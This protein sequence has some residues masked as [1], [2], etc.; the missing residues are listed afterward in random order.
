MRHHPSKSNIVWTV[1]FSLLTTLVLNACGDSNNV[2]APAPPAEPGALAIATSSLPSGNVGIFYDIT[3]APAGGNAPYTWSLSSGSL[4]N[5]LTLAS[6]GRISGTPA[7]VQT[8]SPT[9]RLQDSSVPTGEIVTKQLPMSI[10]A[11]PQPTITTPSPL[12][13]GIVNQVYS[14]T[15]LTV[16][17][18]TPP[19]TWSTVVTPP[20]PA[21][22]TFNAATHTISGTPTATE[23]NVTH[24]FSVADSF[25]PTP[26]T[27]SKGL[28]LTVSAAPLTLGITT[29][30]PLL[31]GTVT[32]TYGPVQLA[33]S[34][35]TPPLTW[36]LVPGS[37]ALPNGLQLSSGGAL[38]GT[39]S[40]AVTVTPVFRVRD[41]ATSP[42]Q[43]AAKPLAISISL[44]AAPNITTTSTSLQPN[45][46]FNQSYSRTLTV[47]NGTPPFVWSFT[48]GSPFPNWLSL[49][50]QTGVISGVP[51]STG[52]FNF[53]VQVTDNTGQSDSTPPSLSITIVPQAPPTITPFTLP[54]GTVNVAYSDTQLAATGGI[55]PYTWTVTPALPNGLFFNLL[56]PGII[57]GTPLAGS[58]GTTSHTFRVT[59][60]TSPT[61]Q[62]S[63]LTR[64]LTINAALTINQNSPLPAGTEGQ[65]FNTTLTASGGAP[66]YT[67]SITGT[68]QPDQSAPG[69]FLSSGGV[70]NGTPSTTTGS[71]FTRT[72][73]VQ[74]NNGV[75]ITKS[76]AITINAALTIDTTSPLPDGKEKQPYGPLT[77]QASG[78][79]P[80][81]NNWGVT[82]D[83][84]TGLRLDASTGEISGE[85][86]I[87]TAGTSTHTFSVQDSTSASASKPNISLTIAP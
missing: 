70:I 87:G 51:N 77:M 31:G 43:T 29:D 13:N 54:N 8:T 12:P 39:P 2:S 21:G 38:S 55:Q 6:S 14:S 49:N 80:P 75:A 1:L 4:P 83:L 28:A 17:G 30:S 61:G 19:Y 9:F 35:G 27:V 53:N 63:E 66:P 78:G 73:R 25:S 10:T 81:Y 42:Q 48:G 16:V 44:P 60:L 85:P 5:G 20:L 65:A 32:Q 74:D 82:P 26:Q 52:V 15:T 37:P 58:N 34:G 57:S 41:A 36:D 7:T 62:F 40:T 23:S 47:Q 45:G 68:G 18:G 79:T 56:G 11:V 64:S 71:P 59:D 3:L 69:L 72:Y 46:T 84:P 33:A 67:W 50:T 22:L 24:T 76:L 86:D